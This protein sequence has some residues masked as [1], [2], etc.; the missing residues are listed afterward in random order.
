MF[1]KI[2][3]VLFVLII[4]AYATEKT[5]ADKSSNPFSIPQL[6]NY[7]GKLTDSNGNAVRDSVYS[8]TFRFFTTLTGGADFWNETQSVQT[9]AGLFNCLLG[10]VT[11]IP[12]IPTDG[13]CYLEMQVNP[14][15]ALTPRIR[16][17]SSAYA[18]IA[19]KADTA[20]YAIS[21]PLTRPI[22]PPVTTAE[23]AD[24][25]I[26]SSKIADGSIIRQ[27]VAI[28]FKAPFSDTA[29]FARGVNILYVDSALVAV[30]SYKLQ[31]NDISALDTRFVNENQPNAISDAMLHDGSVT[32]AKILD[33]TIQMIDLS[34]TPVIRPITPGIT[35]QE[36]SDSVLTTNK[37]KDE[38]ITNV[39]LAPN[40]ITSD[41]ILDNT[42][43]RSDV[44]STFKAPYA[45]TADF[46]RAVNLQYV[47]S[48]RI[49]TNAHK[50]QGKDTIAL[51]LKFVD[52]GQSAGGDLTDSYPNPTIADNAVTTSKIL[53]GTILGADMAKPLLLEGSVSWPSAILRVRNNS[54]GRGI[55]IDS[56]GFIGLYIKY[57]FA[58][59]V[60][61]NRA[62][63]SG[64][65][66]DTAGGPGIRIASAATEGIGI[67]EAG[68]N[69]LYI[70]HAGDNGIGIDSAETY[71]MYAYGAL[72]GGNFVASNEAANG[73]VVH[74]YQNVASDTALQVYGSSYATGGFYTS[75]LKNDMSAPCLISPELGIVTSGTGRLS[76]GKADIDFNPIFA[77]NI[78]DDIPM[79]VTVTP[80]G[81]PAGFLYVAETKSNGF[82]VEL[83]M[84]PG[85]EKNGVDI[86]FDW[87]AFGTLKDYETSLKAQAQWQ[88][89]IQE[90]NVYQ[91]KVKAQKE[92]RNIMYHNK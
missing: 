58:D 24:N 44:I 46:S 41:K 52:E 53:D 70:M 35:T 18:F 17:T 87:I 9:R 85:L 63:Q 42:I 66:I 68:Y 71:G 47:D 7:Q 10:G 28:N 49:S 72:A 43:T 81:K 4:I 38:A 32:S 79:R 73:L 2:I 80:R 30:N 56:A 21:A 31:G 88:K 64:I 69:G 67:D 33:G 90:R 89:M 59:G 51:S 1:K 5:F 77:D 91:A 84:I 61:I 14:N 62:D 8:I 6:L 75:G 16:I 15:P 55:S 83:E 60:N 92:Q 19:K 50:L 26:N 74:S 40:A 65:W 22:T 39:K 25:A 13:N 12:Y 82:K 27:D 3:L 76:N 11:P 36:L 37:I 48:A 29:D 45:D 57:S 86:P 23:I 78:R 34:F 20:S 54:T